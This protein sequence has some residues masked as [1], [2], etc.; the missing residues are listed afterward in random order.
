MAINPEFLKR[1]QGATYCQDSDCPINL[2]RH[3]FSVALNGCRKRASAPGT[4]RAEASRRRDG[5]MLEA[6]YG[7]EYQPTIRA[8]E[9]AA[10]IQ[11]LQW[12]I[13]R[14]EEGKKGVRARVSQDLEVVIET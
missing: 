2:V 9:A 11:R 4:V 1:K 8:R 6:G 12:A 10:S 7:E 3:G 14:R 5:L 13:V